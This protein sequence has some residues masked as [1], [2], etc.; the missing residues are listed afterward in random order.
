M[1]KRLPPVTHANIAPAIC[2]AVLFEGAEYTILPVATLAA[3]G[4][5]W[6]FRPSDG[7]DALASLRSVPFEES[8][9]VRITLRKKSAKNITYHVERVLRAAW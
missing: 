4:M 5:V 3:K 9:P 2:S 7:P 8:F 1:T 6:H